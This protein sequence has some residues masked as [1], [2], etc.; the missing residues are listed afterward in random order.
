MIIILFLFYAHF[1]FILVPFSIMFLSGRGQMM[2]GNAIFSK[3]KPDQL[4]KAKLTTK[5]GNVCI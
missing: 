1:H 2:I 5:S 4:K 3:N